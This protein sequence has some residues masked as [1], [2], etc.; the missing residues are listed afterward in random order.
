MTDE[1]RSPAGNTGFALVG[2][3]YELKP[4]EKLS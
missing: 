4:F 2:G 1:I 3:Q